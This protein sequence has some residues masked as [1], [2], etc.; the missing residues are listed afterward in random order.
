MGTSIP[1][2]TWTQQLLMFDTLL[3]PNKPNA[4]DLM[5]NTKTCSPNSPSPSAMHSIANQPTTLDKYCTR[6]KKSGHYLA[7]CRF[8]IRD[9]HNHQPN[10]DKFCRY[11]KRPGHLL[12]ECRTRMRNNHIT[13]GKRPISGDYYSPSP[14]NNESSIHKKDRYQNHTN[15]NQRRYRPQ[16]NTKPTYP[17]NSNTSNTDNHS[18]A[19]QVTVDSPVR[20]INQNKI[21]EIIHFIHNLTNSSSKQQTPPQSTPTTGIS[22]LDASGNE[23]IS[24][25]VLAPNYPSDHPQSYMLVITD[26]TQRYQNYT[27]ITVDHIINILRQEQ[28]PTGGPTLD[29]ILDI[30]DPFLDPLPQISNDIKDT[31]RTNS[32]LD[33]MCEAP[34]WIT[35]FFPYHDVEDIAQ[36]VT[37]I[38][39]TDLHHNK[40]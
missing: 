29:E 22:E 11:C 26:P 13:G 35:N 19:Y 32:K 28:P 5:N 31:Y 40:L 14:T 9:N 23:V 39:M 4:T 34:V 2:E 20:D 18:H 3:K 6:C 10:N 21:E 38:Q 17:T 15:D 7:E 1:L 27:T 33:I 8:H 37:H 16:P 25:T 24:L 30:C 12:S 36:V